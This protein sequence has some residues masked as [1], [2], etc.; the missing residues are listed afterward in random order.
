MG[1]PVVVEIADK[2]ADVKDVDDVFEYL[3]AIDERFSTY[4]ELSEISRINRGEILPDQY[5]VEMKN[6]LSLCEKTKQET[7]GFFDINFNGKLD[8]SGLVKGF[9]IN[10]ASKLLTAKGYKN[11]YVEI[12]GDVQTVGLNSD[13]QPWAIGI[14]NPFNEKE[15]IKIINVSNRGVATSGTYIR[16]NHI[17]NPITKKPATEIISLTVIGPDIYEADRFATPAFAMGL[18]GIDWLENRVGLEGYLISHDKH[19]IF[20]TGF[21]QYLKNI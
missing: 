4:K 8:P 5:S 2:F 21:S 1:M 18:S 9:A 6:I 3:R 11:F 17:I 20:T 7:E 10:E 16:G 12:A 15:V 13:N 19:A 14:R